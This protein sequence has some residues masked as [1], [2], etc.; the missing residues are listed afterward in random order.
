MNISSIHPPFPKPSR[1]ASRVRCAHRFMRDGCGVRGAPYYK[2][3]QLKG[4]FKIKNKAG[5]EI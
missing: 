3:I 4:R 2:L 5:E 1:L